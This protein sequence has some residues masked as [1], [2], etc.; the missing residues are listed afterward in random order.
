[1][2]IL[3]AVAIALCTSCLQAQ[4]ED[5]FVDTDKFD[6]LIGKEY[7]GVEELGDFK[8]STTMI[9]GDQGG[10]IAW[11]LLKYQ[12]YIIVTSEHRYK[13]D[14]LGHDFF[15]RPKT[16]NVIM[17]VVVLNG[18]YDGCFGCLTSKNGKD[19]IWTIHPDETDEL[20]RANI[21]A[22]LRIDRKTGKFTKADPD[23]LKDHRWDK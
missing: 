10:I 18:E 6:Y 21:L 16:S 13:N 8:G 9:G 7:V 14:T 11:Q 22:T 2:R 17:D 15:G 4:T 23:E 19:K 3:L 12:E 20:K 5:V 1:M